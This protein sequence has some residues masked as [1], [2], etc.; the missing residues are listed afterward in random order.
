MG[1]VTEAGAVLFDKEITGFAIDSR[2]I[3][4]GELFF[5][6]SPEDYKRH[7][8][9]AT[10]FDDAHRFI[11]QAFERGAVAVV[12]R[13]ERVRDDVE[14]RAFSD[15][16]LLVDDVIDALQKVARGVI[17][18]WGGPVIG[19][20]GSAGK[21]TTKDLTA[22]VLMAAG[23]RVLKS[24]KNFNNELGVPL[25]VLQMET[26]GQRPEQYDVAV[27]EMGMSTPG[28]IARLCAIAPPDI[29]VELLVAP[30]HLEFFGSI[31][32]IAEGKAQLI[33]ALKPEGTAI[34]NA[35]DERVARMREKHRGRTITFGM[36]NQSDVMATDIEI[37]QLN[38]SRFRLRT[39][40]GSADVE[41][42]MPG[43]H[44]LMNAL[45]TAAVATVFG[46]SPE[47]IANSL[48][49]GVPSEMRGEI[50]DFA[51]GWTLI[52]DSYN[53]N[54]RSLHSMVQS[55]ATG[56]SRAKRRIVIAGEMLELG[57]EGPRMHREAGHEIAHAGI[58][59]LWGVRG[60]AQEIVK[61]AREAG[62]SREATRFFESAEEAAAALPDEI[63]AHDLVLIKG[64]RG[65]RMDKIVKMLRDRFPLAGEEERV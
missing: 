30:A 59:L 32:K 41:L 3:S 38:L 48:R 16:L 5:A 53:S 47:Q 37:V 44:N 10:S 28:E 57:A 40:L 6:L 52:D 49:S 20:T 45:A 42:P 21:T 11:P 24:I 43:R 4:R 13:R 50:L 26:A 19:I 61:G 23:R 27:L 29:G 33:E 64:S 14:L 8:F 60:L 34:L 9:T 58:D 56:G 65:V 7:C 51:A 22:R 15:R 18:A 1:A 62:M 54:P 39:P 17:D 63:R 46:I 12:A 2:S 25:S 36:E 55:I 35:D 31:E